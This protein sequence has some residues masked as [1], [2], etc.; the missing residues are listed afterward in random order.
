MN[1]VRTTL[2]AAAH[3]ALDADAGLASA[4]PGGFWTGEIPPGQATQFPSAV[5][6]QADTEWE[7][8]GSGGPDLEKIT[9]AASAFAT[10]AA[11][12]EAALDRL[13]SFIPDA[14]YILTNGDWVTYVLP[15]GRT[16]RSEEIRSATGALVFAG[17]LTF[18]VAIFRY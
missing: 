1:P 18:D 14:T 17:D 4:F 13:Q 16:L 9:L 12:L 5:L 11:G 7:F 6:D 8:T 2:L 3:T 15:T 10:T